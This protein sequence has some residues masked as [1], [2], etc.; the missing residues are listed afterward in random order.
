MVSLDFGR[1]YPDFAAQ[2]G[3]GHIFGVFGAKGRKPTLR[4]SH[5]ATGADPL[6]QIIAL[7]RP[8]SRPKVGIFHFR[9]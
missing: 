3:I 5:I 1:R 2:G 7:T 9:A 4:L 8:R 6:G